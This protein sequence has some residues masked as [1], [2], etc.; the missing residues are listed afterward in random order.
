VQLVPERRFDGSG[1]LRYLADDLEPTLDDLAWLIIIVS[2]NTATAML[3]EML[4]GPSKI[5]ATS[6]AHWS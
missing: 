2:D 4:D 6:A 5:N 1:V 3:V